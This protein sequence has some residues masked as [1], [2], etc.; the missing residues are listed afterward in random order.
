[1]A[2]VRPFAGVR[3]VDRFLLVRAVVPALVVLVFVLEGLPTAG[4]PH[5]ASPLAAMSSP[6]SELLAQA[7]ATP[8]PTTSSTTAAPHPASATGPLWTNLTSK[9]APPT[10]SWRYIGTMDYDPVDQY[11]LLFGGYENA[12]AAPSSDSWTFANGHWTELD[13]GGPPARYAAMM[14][15]DAGDGYMLLYGGIDESTTPYTLYNDTWTFVH[16]AWTEVFPSSIPPARW[17]GAMAYD[18]SDNYTV[19]FGGT[20]SEL[21]DSPMKDTWIYQAGVWTNVT[22]KVTGNP[23]A[24]YRQDMTYDAADGY[25]VMFGGCTTSDVVS[26]ADTL[27]Y[28]NYTWTL[29][30]PSTKP[31]GRTYT[32]ITY[33]AAQGY[34]LMFG[35]VNEATNTGLTDTWAFH[36]GTWTDLSSDFTTEQSIRGLEMLAYRSAR[37]L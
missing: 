31:P 7:R 11:V 28:H 23:A 19:L 24:R 8:L 27:T 35:G 2:P 1:M 17:R 26:T 30:N 10:P 9:L 33:D 5:V 3:P 21:T 20:P 6:A 25:I 16:G 12:S 34:V 18:A 29:L 36:N 4:T 14:T 37:R 13:I 22:T 32:G 15:W